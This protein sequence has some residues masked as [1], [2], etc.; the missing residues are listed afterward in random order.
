MRMRDIFGRVYSYFRLAK[1]WDGKSGDGA[2]ATTKHYAFANVSDT[3]EA[4]SG[5]TLTV[6]GIRFLN[7]TRLKNGVDYAN[8]AMPVSNA[9]RRQ[10]RRILAA[11]RVYQ[12]RRNAVGH[13]METRALAIYRKIA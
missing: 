4:T 13:S 9:A 6:P 1:D 11:I 3:G 12:S 8:P 2:L 10:P 5:L 7:R